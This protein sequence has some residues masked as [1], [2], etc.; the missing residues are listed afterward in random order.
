MK[1]GRSAI[2]DKATKREETEVASNSPRLAVIIFSGLKG[3]D[4]LQK[5]GGQ[6]IFAGGGGSRTTVA[7]METWLAEAGGVVAVGSALSAVGGR[8]SGTKS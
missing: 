2:F 8:R 7:S 4:E 1:V 3:G 6:E 5:V